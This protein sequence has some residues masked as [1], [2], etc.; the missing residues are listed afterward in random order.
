MTIKQILLT[1]T[2]LVLA[3]CGNQKLATQLKDDVKEQRESQQATEIQL[4]ETAKQVNELLIRNE[5]I[6]RQ[7]ERLAAL[8]AKLSNF[9][10]KRLEELKEA[11]KPR[12]VSVD[13]AIES[14]LKLTALTD[15]KIREMA[16]PLLSLIGGK[17]GEDRLLELVKT[18]RDPLVRSKAL[19]GLIDMNSKQVTVVLNEAILTSE[20]RNLDVMAEYLG[21][22]CDD[23]SRTPVLAVLQTLNNFT[24]S[25]QSISRGHLY[26]ILAQVGKPE[27][28]KTLKVF[29][30]RER[31]KTAVLAALVEIDRKA[32]V[33]IVN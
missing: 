24:D 8:E 21:K 26:R 30:D 25:R 19:K 28:T 31:S 13:N 20:G 17:Q 9:E 18:D 7:M 2:T 4:R 10:L 12:N 1:V 33:A 29:L 23:T 5:A 6:L 14:V 32:A 22:H 3:G 11:V 16:C 15:P 27:D